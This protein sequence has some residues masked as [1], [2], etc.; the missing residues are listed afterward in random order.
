MRGSSKERAIG[1]NQAKE[2]R[3]EIEAVRTWATP[4]Q[5]GLGRMSAQLRVMR[6]RT[7]AAPETILATGKFQKPTHREIP[8]PSEAL[9][10]GPMLKPAVR[11]VH[12][13]WEVP[14]L[15]A[16]PRVRGAAHARVDR[17][18]NKRKNI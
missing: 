18:V 5:T 10:A 15:V 6:V 9:R 14:V 11:E 16:E 17:A 2:L 13:V 4:Q 3:Q 7:G 12:P 1:R 8:V